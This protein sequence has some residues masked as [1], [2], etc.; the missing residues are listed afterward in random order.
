MPNYTHA[1]NKQS[2]CSNPTPQCLQVAKGRTSSTL[3]LGFSSGFTGV[4]TLFLSAD[5]PVF[6]FIP[7][8]DSEPE[9]L[10][11]SLLESE[12]ELPESDSLP[13]EPRF[14]SLIRDKH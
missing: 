11:E 5:F 6:F 12:L 7:A 4:T 8:S 1:K 2:L 10:S 3:F 13:S 14:R 9:S